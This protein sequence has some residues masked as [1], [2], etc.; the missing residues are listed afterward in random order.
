MAW[1][2]VAGVS[3]ATVAGAALGPALHALARRL[4]GLRPRPAGPWLIWPCL[5]GALCLGAPLAVRG[6]GPTAALQAVVLCGLA[7]GALADA[8]AGIIPDAVNLALLALGVLAAPLLPSA[9]WLTALIDGCVAAGLLAGLALAFARLAHRPGLGWG[10]VKLLGAL[11]ACLGLA[12]A[13]ATL[14]LAAATALL[15][16]GV[17]A[18]WRGWPSGRRLAFGP[19]LALWGGVALL[20]DPH[21]RPWLNL[22]LGAPE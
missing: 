18:A 4:T 12:N 16:A 3:G 14:F 6:L 13:L 10:D 17:V 8:M 22:L 19:Y 9:D 1:I 2:D 7:V 5:L 11:G 15:W 20:V 21:H